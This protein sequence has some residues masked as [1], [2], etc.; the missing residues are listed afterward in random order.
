[1]NRVYYSN[2]TG[3]VPF[4]WEESEVNGRLHF[5]CIEDLF[6]NIEST[7]WG[8][9]SI[10]VKLMKSLN[11]VWV[12]EDGEVIHAYKLDEENEEKRAEMGRCKA[13]CCDNYDGDEE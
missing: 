9:H 1:M 10:H 13:P 6:E 2:L 8:D 7:H 11:E 3:K 12:L 5:G 4:T